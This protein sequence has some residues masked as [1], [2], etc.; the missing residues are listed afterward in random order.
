MA[1]S[2][3]T[4]TSDEET[5]L[6]AIIRDQVAGLA[7]QGVPEYKAF[8]GVNAKSAA[9]LFC[10]RIDKPY[11]SVIGKTI[12]FISLMGDEA[13]Q[14]YKASRVNKELAVVQPVASEK[15]DD[16]WRKV[17]AP[18]KWSPAKGEV[19]QGTY[20]GSRT[21]MGPHD[22]YTQYLVARGK[23][24][25]HVSGTVIDQLFSASQVRPGSPVR[26][27]FN[28]TNKTST[29]NSCHDFDLFVKDDE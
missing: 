11:K 5:V 8:Q 9:I 25:R 4:W 23:E 22:M 2:K 14:A 21:S 15:P 28:G 18:K 16:G 20:I 29:G 12:H 26:V 1:K 6:R 10:A 13:Y 17:E 24:V 3:T 19:L 7:L 27:V